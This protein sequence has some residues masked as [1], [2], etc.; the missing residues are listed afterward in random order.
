MY[1]FSQNCRKCVNLYV[2]RCGFLLM[3]SV[4]AL[5][6]GV[7]NLHYK[8]LW[9][10]NTAADIRPDSTMSRFLKPYRDTLLQFTT[11]VVG[12]TDT[13]YFPERPSGNLGNLCADLTFSYADSLLKKRIGLPLDAAVINLGGLRT[14]LPSGSIT[15]GNLYEV[16]P[17]ENTEVLLKISGGAMDSLL[18]HIVKRGGEPVSGLKI[19]VNEKQEFIAW[20]GNS[21]FDSRRDYWI[22]TS[23]YLM[24]GGDGYNMFRGA[25]EMIATEKTMRGIFTEGI[26]AE[27]AKYGVVRKRTERRI[28]YANEAAVPKK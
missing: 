10:L 8:A 24:N 11:T 3:L 17:F 18:R 23:D 4:L 15:V 9:P 5:S 1:H 22:A 13:G 6:C 7:K 27:T 2:V 19:E 12:K 14:A 26:R 20:I 25:L 28:V 21:R 16:M